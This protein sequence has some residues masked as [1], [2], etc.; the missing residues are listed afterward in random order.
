ME[1][2]RDKMA[3]KESKSSCA[4]ETTNNNPSPVDDGEKPEEREIVSDNKN[5]SS[6]KTMMMV[7]VTQTQPPSFIAKVF[8]AR[9]AGTKSLLS[10]GGEAY[11]ASKGYKVT[12]YLPLVTT[13]KIAKGFS[14]LAL[15]SRGGIHAHSEVVFQWIC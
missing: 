3:E 4:E 9:E 2:F 8:S 10:D 15:N 11:T 14:A 6:A 7:V 13:E 5:L 12:L 1:R